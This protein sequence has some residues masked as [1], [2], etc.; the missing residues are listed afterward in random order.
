MN[1]GLAVEL[2]VVMCL[3]WMPVISDYTHRAQNKIKGTFCAA[4]AYCFS[5]LMYI[6]GLGS[7]VHFQ[8]NDICDIFALSGLGVIALIVILLSTI[9]TNFVAINSASLCFNHLVNR[10]SVKIT[11]ILICFL[12]IV[13]GLFYFHATV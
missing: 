6:I 5:S 7:T 2:S 9:T 8:T 10:A 12:S 11:F 1:F 4:A 13:M 3:S